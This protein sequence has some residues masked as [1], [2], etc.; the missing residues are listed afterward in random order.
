MGGHPTFGRINKMPIFEQITKDLT[1]A[2]K[3]KDQLRLDTLRMV[4]SLFKNREID[5]GRSL[6]DQE[7][8]KA[9]QTLVKQRREAA[10]Q[11]Q[12][13]QRPELADKE[14]AELQIIESYLPAAVSTAEIEAVV[15][16]T[17]A[18]VG[19]TTAKDIGN[20]MKALMGKFAGKS[21]DGKMV[22]NFVRQKLSN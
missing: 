18:E 22:N 5:L 15:T 9:L 3:A 16:A 1:Q 17:I 10:E 8:Q 12:K 4:K 20:V 19:A 7:A 6:D 14:L 21:V 13:A 11:Y 2:M